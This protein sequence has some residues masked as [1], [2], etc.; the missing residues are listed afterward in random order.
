MDTLTGILP[1]LDIDAEDLSDTH[2]HLA[3]RA[4]YSASDRRPNIGQCVKTFPNPTEEAQDLRAAYIDYLVPGI[5]RE[6]VD[7]TTFV[8]VDLPGISIENFLR[9]NGLRRGDVRPAR[10]PSMDE[11]ESAI[12]RRA[13]EVLIHELLHVPRPVLVTTS[14]EEY[15]RHQE[16]EEDFVQEKLT[17]LGDHRLPSRLVDVRLKPKFTMGDMANMLQAIQNH[18]RATPLG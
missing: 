8:A 3:H 1:T 2:I 18:R 5:P 12:C 9:I 7:V 16:G 10:E 17:E 14:E 4:P 11:L 6:K 13:S 15:E